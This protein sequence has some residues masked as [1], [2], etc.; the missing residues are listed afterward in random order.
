MPKR[1]G[2]SIA[3]I[4]PREVVIK[5]K[6]KEEK[7]IIIEIIKKRPKAGELFGLLKGWKKS[8]QEIKNEAREGWLSVSDREREK[9]WKTKK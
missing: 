9:R 8:S 2:S 5:E 7:P 4:I 6:I 1:W 3:V